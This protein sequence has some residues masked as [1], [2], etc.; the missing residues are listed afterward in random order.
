MPCEGFSYKSF[1]ISADALKL[2]LQLPAAINSMNLKTFITIL[3]LIGAGAYAQT[4]RPSDETAAME[5]RA[6]Q[7]LNRGEFASALLL[8]QKVAERV[9]DQPDRLARIQEKIRFCRKNLSDPPMDPQALTDFRAPAVPFTDE[10]RKEH[11]TPR[12]GET[13]ELSIQELGNFEYDP[14]KGGNIPK[15]VQNLS[16]VRISTRGFMI[17]LNQA[18]HV[19][20]FALVADLFACCFGQPPQLQHTIIVRCP[21]GK[22]TR[23]FPDEITVEGTLKVQEKKDDGFIVSLFEINA[24]SVKPAVK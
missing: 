22:T 4:T 20:E 24:A 3:L 15:D 12:P 18:D 14:E 19:T 7:T 9:K 2:I 16:G 13:V 17:P 6:V 5:L 1:F 11:Q 8:L 21:A 10:A 23:Y